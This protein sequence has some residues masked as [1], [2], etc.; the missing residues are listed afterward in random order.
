MITGFFDHRGRAFV[1]CQLVI[2]RLNV[3]GVVELRVDTGAD[4]TS[5]HPGAST[6]LGLPFDRLEMQNPR[7]ASGLG[8]QIVYFQEPAQLLF[9]DDVGGLERCD[10]NLL[11]AEPIL[12]NAALPSLLGLDV[13]NRWRMN[14][15]PRNALLQFFA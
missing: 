9:D 15:D 2:P 10:V 11:I 13:L 5:L 14:F 12:R 4:G 8:G 3:T 6:Y 1:G 7:V